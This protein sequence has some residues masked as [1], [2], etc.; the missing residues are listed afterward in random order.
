[1]TILEERA[2]SNTASDNGIRWLAPLF[3][4]VFVLIVVAVLW[5][6]AQRLDEVR[7]RLT[8]ARSVAVGRSE[9]DI[10]T[11]IGRPDLRITLAT[12]LELAPS[13]A[14]VY[15]SLRGS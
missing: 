13:E 4:S 15:K 1:M 8:L 10:Q 9:Q 6:Q 2:E 3:Q 12:Q 5:L 11:W 7:H 14:L